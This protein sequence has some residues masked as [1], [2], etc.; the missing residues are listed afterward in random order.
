MPL[1]LFSATLSYASQHTTA[2]TNHHEVDNPEAMSLPHRDDSERRAT[3]EEYDRVVQMNLAGNRKALEAMYQ[4][5]QDYILALVKEQAETEKKIATH[6]DTRLSSE[7]AL[8]VAT[9]EHFGGTSSQPSSGSKSENVSPMYDRPRPD[10]RMYL[11]HST[12]TSASKPLLELPQGHPNPQSLRDKSFQKT[13]PEPS[14]RRN[15]VVV[16]NRRIPND[17]TSARELTEIIAEYNTVATLLQLPSVY[18][19]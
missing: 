2:S 7:P 4:A 6:A 9:S 15:A 18:G 17:E 12:R 5:Q 14:T 16:H 8:H 1:S 3:T 19:G 10:N 11:S 13:P